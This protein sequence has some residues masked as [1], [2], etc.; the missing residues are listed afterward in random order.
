MKKPS[1]VQ[2]MYQNECKYDTFNITIFLAS[3][4]K[5]AFKNLGFEEDDCHTI[6]NLLS[7]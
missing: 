2:N 3:A 1:E 6:N 4:R 5:N 7:K